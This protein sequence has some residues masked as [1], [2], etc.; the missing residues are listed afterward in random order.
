MSFGRFAVATAG[1]LGLSLVANAFEVRTFQYDVPNQASFPPTWPPTVFPFFGNW[2]TSADA[3]FMGI[4][5]PGLQIPRLETMFSLAGVPENL[6]GSLL[7]VSIRIQGYVNIAYRLD[8]EGGVTV[9]T[10]TLAGTI[11]TKALTETAPL[12]FPAGGNVLSVLVSTNLPLAVPADNDAAPDFGGADSVVGNFD[13]QGEDSVT[14]LDGD[15]EFA[16]FNNNS[17]SGYIYLPI[18]FNSPGA[19]V[20]SGNFGNESDPF[21]SALVTV[22]YTFL[23]ESDYLFGALPVVFAGWV[24]RRRFSRA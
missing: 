7:Q 16:M 1:L 3:T 13:G 20:S 8:N 14:Y 19:S 17:G 4:S 24:L 18:S 9:A 5:D 15:T 21:G 12:V 2:D 11:A 22:T 10:L 6:Q 23:P